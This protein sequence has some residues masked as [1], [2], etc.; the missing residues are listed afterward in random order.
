MY[1]TQEGGVMMIYNEK[2]EAIGFIF[3][4]PISGKKIIMK[5][6]E[7]SIEEIAELLKSNEIIK[8]NTAK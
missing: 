2:G 5:A 8:N 6:E 1:T 3:R 7:M 4:E